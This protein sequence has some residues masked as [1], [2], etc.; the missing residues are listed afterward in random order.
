MDLIVK[1]LPP[2]FSASIH[3]FFRRAIIVFRQNRIYSDIFL[4][5][6]PY[7]CIYNVIYNKQASGLPALTIRSQI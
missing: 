3:S 2:R 6:P 4:L 1:T 7:N 5:F